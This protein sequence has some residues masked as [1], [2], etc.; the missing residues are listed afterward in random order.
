MT[1]RLQKII[2]RA[3]LCSRRAA[4]EL[5]RAGK[6]TVNGAVA[7][8]GDQADPDTDTI[9]V[10]G[11]PLQAAP[12]AVYLMLHKPRGYVTTLS[13]E[14][15]R[16]TAAE[17]VAD[18]GERVFPVGRLDKES[19]GL[20]LF[21]NDGALMQRLIHPS[22]EVDKTY[23]VTVRGA[24]ETAVDK[25][26]ALRDVEGEPICPARVRL[27]ERRLRELVLEIVIHEGKNR[28]IR[29]MCRQ[30][31]LEVARLQ[32]VGEHTLTLGKLPA[33]QWRYLTEDEVRILKGSEQA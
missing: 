15:G 1:E 17:L 10:D 16:K 22:G 23:H 26:S 28:Q 7:Y 31:G 6:V 32:R 5:L 4:E 13:D 11:Q 33:G 27:L 19:E 20:L 18:C 8:L 3:G 29:R 21:T 14:Y 2:A 30:C 12:K 9:T 24:L 25:L